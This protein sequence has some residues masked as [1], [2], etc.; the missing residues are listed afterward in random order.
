MFIK[1]I[2]GAQPNLNKLGNWL[3]SNGHPVKVILRLE[4]YK[5]LREFVW[6]ALFPNERYR[7]MLPSEFTFFETLFVPAE[8]LPERLDVLDLSKE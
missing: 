8:P 3:E 1:K 6:G 7:H 2:L 5:E 4:D